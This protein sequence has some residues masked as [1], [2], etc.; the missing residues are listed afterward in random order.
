MIGGP[1]MFMP[2]PMPYQ[3][4]PGTPQGAPPMPRQGV[5]QQQQ[6]AGGYVPPR[7]TPPAAAPKQTAA[8]PAPRAA[9]GARPAEPARAAVAI[10]SP[11][12]LGITPA[13]GA[14]KPQAAALDWSAARRQ[15]SELGVTRF[16][17]EQVGSGARFTCWV[18]GEMVQADGANE[19]EAV[20]RCLERARRPVANRR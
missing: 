2:Q 20:G 7:L 9:R 8:Q 15:M 11:E 6:Q 17:L 3:G 18:G 16:Q 13:G 12:E 10:P 19:V 14:A 1:P 5:P 4:M